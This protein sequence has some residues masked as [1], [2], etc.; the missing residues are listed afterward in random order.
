M[1]ES[2]KK[3]GPE[4]YTNEQAFEIVIPALDLLQARLENGCKIVQQSGGWCL[5]DSDDVCVCFGQTISKMLIS[6]IFTEC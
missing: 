4:T 1:K 5:R 6:L 3:K 2:K